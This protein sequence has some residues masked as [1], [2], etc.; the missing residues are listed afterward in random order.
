MGT[1]RAGHTV[2]CTYLMLQ[3]I[4]SSASNRSSLRKT[5]HLSGPALIGS[6]GWQNPNT[7]IKLLRY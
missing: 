6:A 7:F 5:T 2:Y 4:N 1:S 3:R